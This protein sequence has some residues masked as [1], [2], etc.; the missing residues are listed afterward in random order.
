MTKRMN[1]IYYYPHIYGGAPEKVSLEV[2]KHL[3][4]CRGDI[5][6]DLKV[7][8]TS[9]GIRSIRKYYEDVDIV[10]FSKLKKISDESVIYIPKSPGIAP[11]DR[12]LLYFY[13]IV[14]KIPII[15][16]YH[17]D[18]RIELR[19]HLK[20]KDL[21]GFVWIAP[22]SFLAPW[23]LRQNYRIIVHSP[24]MAQTLKEKYLIEKNVDV[25]PN[26]ID[27]ELFTKKIQQIELDGYPSIFYH[28]GLAY[29]KG[30]GVLLR[31]FGLVL[32]EENDAKLYIAGKGHLGRYLRK[33]C[34]KLNIKGRV[35]FLGHLSLL[36]I[37]S[38]LKSV[39]AAIY[40]SEY[41]SF[42]LAMLEALALSNCPVYMSKRA[43]I[44]DFIRKGDNLFTFDPTI[45]KISHLLESVI[46]NTIN[47]KDIVQ[48]QKNFAK[49]FLW[50]KVI[51]EYYIPFFNKVRDD[52]GG[53]KK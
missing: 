51:E 24:L 17:G 14:K 43:G 8:T 31:A 4:K 15:S 40:P 6:F 39:D 49:R 25:I 36:D 23:I 3:F 10:S 46:C 50:E 21:F 52:L 9:S 18:F 48:R 13:A 28:G 2:F 53:R 37:S 5:P 12:T 35:E 20:N 11:N 34:I 42:S 44:C 22:A 7:F 19:Y 38:Y 32:K 29:E 47:D 41:D 45:P 1:L 26:G 30:I 27:D 16:A 33:L